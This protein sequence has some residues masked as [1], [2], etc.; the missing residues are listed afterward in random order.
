VARGVL[1]VELDGKELPERAIPILD[2]DGVHSVSV[3]LGP[4]G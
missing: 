3:T 4:V 1:R 2:D